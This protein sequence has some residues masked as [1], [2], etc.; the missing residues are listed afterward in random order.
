MA[1]KPLG[2]WQYY[3]MYLLQDNG[4]STIAGLR[5]KVQPPRRAYLNIQDIRTVL[6]TLEKR[7]I[8]FKDGHRYSLTGMYRK[9]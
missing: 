1:K 9:L 6:K 4:P 5:E 2:S 8:V 3:L 7:G